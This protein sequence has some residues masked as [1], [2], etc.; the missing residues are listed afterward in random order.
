[1]MRSL[2]K[3]FLL[4]DD[5]ITISRSLAYHTVDKRESKNQFSNTPTFVVVKQFMFGDINDPKRC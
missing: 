4:N 2:R 1:M 3:M 5:N